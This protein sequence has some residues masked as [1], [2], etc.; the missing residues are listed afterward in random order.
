MPT[1]SAD[2]GGNINLVE[3]MHPLNR[4]LQQNCNFRF[5]TII[6]INTIDYVN[7]KHKL[8]N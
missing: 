4:K 6:I 8:G 2:P 3:I 7:D 5:F 1:G